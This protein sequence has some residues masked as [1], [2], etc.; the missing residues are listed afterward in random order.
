MSDERLLD[1]SFWI[2]W[3]RDPDKHVGLADRYLFAELW[4]RAR[5]ENERLR[6]ALQ[7]IVR[8]EGRSE[9]ASIYSAPSEFAEIAR[10]ALAA[11]PPQSEKP[12]PTKGRGKG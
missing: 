4:D 2:A 9:Y 6:A 5:V 10:L 11:G 1:A 8:R 7:E 12:R 3:L